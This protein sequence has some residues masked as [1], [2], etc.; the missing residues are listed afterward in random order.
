MVTSDDLVELAES[1][2]ERGSLPGS[3]AFSGRLVRR[4]PMVVVVVVIVVAAAGTSVSIH[5]DGHCAIVLAR[6]VQY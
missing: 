2:L 3:S 4:P 1:I 5:A 6:V